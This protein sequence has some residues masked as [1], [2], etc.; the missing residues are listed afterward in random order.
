MKFRRQLLYL[1]LTGM[2]GAMSIGLI[3]AKVI[4][5]ALPGELGQGSTLQDDQVKA[6]MDEALKL[7]HVGKPPES[8]DKLPVS[9]MSLVAKNSSLR[10]T[11]SAVQILPTQQNAQLLE[12]DK[13]IER[14]I[15]GGQVHI[16]RLMLT[17]GEYVHIV[18][19]QR[20]VDVVVR[21]LGPD[22]KEI[23]AVDSPNGT[24]GPE[25]VSVVS[26]ES[27]NYRL[28]VRPFDDK[29]M[30]GSYAVK[31]DVARDA[32]TQDKMRFVVETQAWHL[33]ENGAQLRAEKKPESLAAAVKVYGEALDLWRSIDNS[34]GEDYALSY[35]AGLSRD[36][37]E[38]KAA[39]Q[40]YDQ[41]LKVR[42]ALGNRE[43]EARALESVGEIFLELADPKKAL[44]YFDQ[45]VS[46]WRALGDVHGEI[47]ALEYMGTAYGA[48]GDTPNA[49]DRLKAAQSIIQRLGDRKGEAEVIRIIAKTY[50]DAGD[51]KT[52]LDYY[53]EALRGF[54]SLKD[55]LNQA[56]TIKGIG[57]VIYDLGK[58]Q[59]ALGYFQRALTLFETTGNGDYIGA[60]LNDIGNAYTM[61]SEKDKALA[62]YEKALALHKSRG[63]LDDEAITLGNIGWLFETQN[64]YPKALDNL[65]KALSL[66][67]E[68]HNRRG[69]AY[70][71]RLIGN[72]YLSLG[73]YEKAL[74]Y[75]KQAMQIMVEVGD[76]YG[77]ALTLCSLGSAYGYVGDPQER[78]G[79]YQKSLAMYRE[80][81]DKWGESDVVAN[82]ASVLDEMGNEDAALKE[83]QRAL[84][85]EREVS[86]RRREADTLT[87]IAA[88]YAR[89]GNK[90]AALQ[91]LDNALSIHKSI[92]YKGCEACT[93][94]LMGSIYQVT[95][96]QSDQ[97]EDLQKALDYYHQAI[98]ANEHSRNIARLEEF[99]TK[100][101]VRFA[102]MYEQTIMLHKRLGQ[103]T[104]AFDLSERARA[105][106]F[107]DQIGNARITSR[108]TANEKL[109]GKEQEIRTRLREIER[110]L[111]EEQ[112]KVQSQSGQLTRQAL[113]RELTN[114]QQEYEDVLIDL[115][116]SDPAYASLRS[117]SPLK[118][119]AVQKLLDPD[120]TLLSYF[121][122]KDSTLVFIITH[123][124]FKMCE[125]PVTE[126]QLTDQISWFRH[127]ANLNNQ[128]PASLVQLYKSLIFPIKEHIKTPLV[129][130]V[131]N[132]ILHYLPFA[133]LT[134]GTRYFGDEHAIYYL[135]SASVLQFVSG[136]RRLNENRILALSQ[137]R[138]VGW[139]TLQYA[140]QEAEKIA[141]IYH[142]Q[143]LLTPNA[144]KSEFLT[145]AG[146]YDIV[147]ITAHGQL[148]NV[149]P[150][151]SRIILA[152]ND[153]NDDGSVAVS[154]IYALALP[155]MS[156]VVLSACETQLGPQSKGDD[157]IGLNR[158]FIYAGTPSVIAS[159]W[160]VDDEATSILMK[161]FY[162]HLRQGMSKAES[163]RTAQRETRDKYPH[164][165]YWAAFVL[166]GDPGTGITPN[167]KLN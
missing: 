85:L 6:L 109:I 105:R 7:R 133:A 162:T 60:V 93:L 100:L 73:E 158:A 17:A 42:R 145:R 102:D 136:R 47:R 96:D 160:T 112:V 51:K 24:Q 118:L 27:G 52:A 124:S 37:H 144:T 78:L 137:S 101:E 90:Q 117:V 70:T 16:Y 14:E 45:E 36:L 142:T 150:L 125:L 161:S 20:G 4:A 63:D 35:L 64:E 134:D 135:P 39:L 57:G 48:F 56:I 81:G 164:P 119:P 13:P 32:T 69:E 126:E 40:Y 22:E 41:V 131:P 143:A 97:K 11:G 103:P 155:K 121:V 83:Y 61:L 138:A 79:F 9:G 108:G 123:N 95:G 148:N 50:D 115:K 53:N 31:I 77:E 19:D 43:G 153:E 116:V 98:D 146:G 2:L 147:H 110:K 67:R 55:V 82:I 139:P 111:I 25:P 120:T 156:V 86:N 166:T 38:A 152:P 99:K 26:T 59:E 89:R 58:R 72:V 75:C 33:F 34:Q 122:L 151:F 29:A 71:L 18:V 113:E 44:G 65:E 30:R 114:S 62:S 54:E 80:I 3:N 1:L 74:S 21:L 167:A 157:I 127:F 76:R 88:I 28:E 106:T 46:V 163:L 12:Y 104:E 154:D 23:V 91:Y 149:H 159:L 66:K 132:G 92:N 84:S 87:S 49:V 5:R 68:L 128:R 107:L 129:G 165:Y 130:I 10:T 141:E 140:D 15:A 94:S 8:L